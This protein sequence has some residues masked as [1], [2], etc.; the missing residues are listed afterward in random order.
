MG[1]DLSGGGPAEIMIDP[2]A[3]WQCAMCATINKPDS[4]NCGACTYSK[5]K[6]LQSYLSMQQEKAQMA[7]ALAASAQLQEA[8]V[9]E[10]VDEDTLRQI[11]EQQQAME[12]VD[13]DSSEKP[14]EAEAEVEAD[15]EAEKAQKKVAAEA[16]K[17]PRSEQA[18]ESAA[19][20]GA[21]KQSAEA[22]EAVES[23]EAP[24]E[25]AQPAEDAEADKGGADEK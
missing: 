7:A 23:V 14:K 22:V 20:D 6:S 17:E 19:D 9:N 18:Q 4:E 25:A 13:A 16:E 3:E 15:A 21:S 24:S 12:N 11:A 8:T 2:N 5:A 10:E 1:V